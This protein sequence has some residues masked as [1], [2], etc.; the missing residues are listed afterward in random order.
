M[1]VSFDTWAELQTAIEAWTDYDFS[2]AQ[3]QEFIGL[4]EDHF[5]LTIFT[6]DREAALSLTVDAQSEALPTDFWGFKSG[7]YVDAAT[8]VV[9]TRLEPGDLRATYPDAMT[10]TP[11]H[12]AIEGENILFGPTPST[13]FT[14]KGTYWQTIPALSGSATSNWLLLLHPRVYL[15]ASLAEAFSFML[16]EA[17]EAKYIAR[18]DQAIADINRAGARRSS[19]SGPLVASHSIGSVPNIQA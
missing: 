19:N 5:Q 4:A 6:P 12:F 2:D 10:G 1:A 11:A 8:D 9:L 18:R 15:Y 17:R 13:S 16:D 3:V 7:P 14:V